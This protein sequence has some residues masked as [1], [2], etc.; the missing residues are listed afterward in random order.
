MPRAV[1]LAGRLATLGFADTAAAQRL[2]AEELRLD[3]L[4]SDASIA[5]ALASAPDPDLAAAALARLV[6]DQD[7]LAALRADQ[8]LRARLTAVLGTST[9]LADHLRRHRADWRLLA[10]FDNGRPPEPGDVAAAVAR[11]TD[12]EQLRI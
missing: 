3:L 8:G 9:A 11:G 1:T 6:P 12:P 7:L 5:S 2:L 10:S 4:G